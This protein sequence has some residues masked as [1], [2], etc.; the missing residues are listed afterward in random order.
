MRRQHEMMGEFNAA[1]NLTIDTDVIVGNGVAAAKKNPKTLDSALE[2]RHL[3]YLPL[4]AVAEYVLVVLILIPALLVIGVAALII[5]LTSRGTLFYTQTR[6]G[7]LGREFAV[8]KLRTMVHDAETVTGPVWASTD[9][10]RVTGVGRFLRNTHIDEFPQLFNVLLGQMSL[11]GPRPERPEFFP[12]L[13]R[14]LPHYRKRLRLKPGITG[15]AQL[16]LPPDSDFDSSR[17]KLRHDLYYGS[18]VSPWL[19]C[20]ITVSTCIHLLRSVLSH[21]LSLIQL[22]NCQ[23]VER[24][25]DAILHDHEGSTPTNGMHPLHHNG[26]QTVNGA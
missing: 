22:P 21:T 16:Q 10:N 9:D 24:E 7:K 4:K 14:E 5:K 13:Q 6:V 8:I 20:R 11:I 3:W 15:L 25:V 2:P 19:D 1:S 23:S 17:R 12:K 26:A 18:H